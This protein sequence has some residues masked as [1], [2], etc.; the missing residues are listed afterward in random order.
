MSKDLGALI[1]AG[2]I[3]VSGVLL[4]IKEP[5]TVN[6]SDSGV[7]VTEGNLGATSGPDVYN[8]Y[9]FHDG[10]L[11]VEFT[12]GGDVLQFTATS[13]QAARTLTQIEL[14]DNSV[15]EIVSTSSPALTLTLPA[16]STLTTVLPNAGDSRVWFLTNKHASATTT[17][18]AAGTGIILDEP[19]GQNVVIAGGNRARIEC[20]RDTT[21]DV[22]CSVD[23]HIDAD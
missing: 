2:A 19:D 23:E 15:I 17:T 9:R 6:V 12:Q 22:V 18:V 4:F 21:T 20:F 3:L 16:T 14:R 13:T 10:L 11:G 7:Q 8:A 1:L 5:V